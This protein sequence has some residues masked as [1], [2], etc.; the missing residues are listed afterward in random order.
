M[1]ELLRYLEANGFTCYIVSGGDRDFMR[2]M[3]Q[4]LLRHPARAGR[5]LG[6]RPQL[7]RGRDE[8]RYAQRLR[9]HGRRTEKPVRIWSGSGGARSSRSATPTATCRCSA[10][11]SGPGEPAAR[12]PRR[13]R[14]AATNRTTRARRRR[15]PRRPGTAGPIVACA[16]TGRQ[17]S[18]SPGSRRRDGD[19]GRSAPHPALPH[20]GRL[21]AEL[22]GPRHPGRDL[23]RCCRH[24]AGDGV[25]DDREPAGSGRPVHLHGADVR[26]RDA[27]R[28]ARDERLDDVD[29]RDPH[30]DDARLGR[31]GGAL[32]RHRRA[33][34]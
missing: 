34:W 30:G 14:D 2:P 16:T 17:S 23:G 6:R 27:R 28:L 11:R 9:V 19:D 1:I 22:A 24:P 21:P 31:R 18:P 5:R 12:A 10:T 25:R 3:T 13:H 20:P 7:R 32:G 33:T 29:D 8:V 4:R 15:W 26:V